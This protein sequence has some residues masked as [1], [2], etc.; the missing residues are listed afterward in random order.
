MKRK[1]SA[2]A[3][4][5]RGDNLKARC[6]RSSLVLGIGVVVAKGLTFGSKVILARLLVPQ[7]LGLMVLV[8]SITSLFQVLTEIGIKQSV[9]QNKNGARPE[10]LNMA[11]W[12]QSL[13]G[14]GLYVV[15]FFVAPFLCQFYFAN[16]PEVLAVHT[17]E[18]LLALVRVAFLAIL[19]WGFISPRVYVLEK[20]IRFGKKVVLTQGSAI[21]G[22]IVT[23][24]LAFVMRNVWALVIGFASMGFVEC[25][26]SYILC[27][28]RPRLSFDWESFQHIYRFARGIFGLP[29]L[30]YI[31]FNIDVLVAGKLV[32][33]SLVGL[34]GMALALAVAPR[35]LFTRIISPILLPAFAEKQDDRKALCRA[36]L[37]ITKVTVLFAIPLVVLAAMCSKTVLSIVYGAQYS[38]VAVP[39]SLLC[40]YALLLIIGT[41]LGNLFFGI[42]QP[43]KHRTFVAVRVLILG[44]LIFPAIKLFGLTGAATTLLLASFIALCAQVLV[45]HRVI[46][47]RVRDYVM[48]WVHGA[49][50]AIPVLAVIVVVRGFMPD[51]P[52]VHLTVGV[53]SCIIVFGLGLLLPKFLDKRQRHERVGAKAVGLVCEKETESA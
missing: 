45:L 3:D 33:T 43:A 40:I 47:L 44:V 7:E 8:L 25:L 34:Y 18:E 51:S 31:A 39:F 50:L 26:L 14:V 42:G 4:Q 38:A 22:A 20:E 32:S 24:V 16:R 37:K 28:F 53:L 1:I 30:T 27:P 21:I 23:I 29:V 5:F 2:I 41:I 52:M 13:R 19:F 49:V 9:I 11:W 17:T 15:A 35:E 6:A 36:V 48:S 46:G 10:Y 12:F